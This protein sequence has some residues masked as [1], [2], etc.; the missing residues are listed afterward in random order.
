MT[1]PQITEDQALALDHENLL[2]PTDAEIEKPADEVEAPAEA[3]ADGAPAEEQEEPTDAA[4][5]EDELATIKAENAR[6]LQEAAE[7]KTQIDDQAIDTHI[8]NYAADWA[9]KHAR[10]LEDRGMS[11]EEAQTQAETL[12]MSE[13]R[14][15]KAEFQLM[16]E[17]QAHLADRLSREHGVSVESLMVYGSAPEMRAAAKIMGPQARELDGVKKELA[18]FKK[19]RI[20]AQN[21]NQPGSKG[22]SVPTTANEILTAIGDDRLDAANLSEKQKATLKAADAL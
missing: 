3:P 2:P 9:V 13:G 21:Y 12:A 17:R 11:A 18:Q 19:D 7:R 15:A 1:T 14:A 4:P 22:N 10:V 20:P 8:R 5:A 16:Q 6:L